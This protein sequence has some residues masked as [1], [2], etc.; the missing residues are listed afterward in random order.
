M[1]LNQLILGALLPFLLGGIHVLRRLNP[2]E[3]PPSPRFFVLWPLALAAG[4][5]WAVIPDLPRLFGDQALYL[6]LSQM[7]ACD[8]FFGHYTIDRIEF[9]SPLLTLLWFGMAYAVLAAALNA[10][11]RAESHAPPIPPP[12]STPPP[13][14]TSV[15]AG[16][17]PH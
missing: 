10:L 13:P 4:A 6:R 7:P 15:S 11:L 1:N 3:P 5:L 17:P 9:D 14:F 12:H 16:W 8:I 2:A